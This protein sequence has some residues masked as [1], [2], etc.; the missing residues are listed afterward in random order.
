MSMRSPID[1]WGG[2]V[3][4]EGVGDAKRIDIAESES[5]ARCRLAE[6]AGPNLPLALEKRYPSVRASNGLAG[7]ARRIGGDPADIIWIV[8]LRRVADHVDDDAGLARFHQRVES[9][10]GRYPPE[11]LRQAR[12]RVV[13]SKVGKTCSPLTRGLFFVDHST[14]AGSL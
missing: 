4:H 5:G 10:T 9:P 8:R 11:Q 6:R 7:R 1:G 2:L 14:R 3:D 13:A 12:R